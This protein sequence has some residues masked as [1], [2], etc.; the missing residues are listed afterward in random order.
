MSTQFLCRRPCALNHLQILYRGAN[1]TH[2]YVYFLSN[3]SMEEEDDDNAFYV[4][5]SISRNNLDIRVNKIE[6]KLK[7]RKWVLIGMGLL[8]VLMG[9]NSIN[10]TLKLAFK[11]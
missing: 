6:E 9:G 10:N 3:M 8:I 4:R 2:L 11:I 5:R 1:T 7:F